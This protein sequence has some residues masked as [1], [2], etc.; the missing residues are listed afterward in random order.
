MKAG[1]KRPWAHVH[2]KLKSISSQKDPFPAAKAALRQGPNHTFQLPLLILKFPRER[3]ELFLL[4]MQEGVSASQAVLQKGVTTL[5]NRCPGLCRV[6]R[7]WTLCPSS[8]PVPAT[9]MFPGNREE[10]SLCARRGGH[11]RAHSLRPGS[12][13]DAGRLVDAPRGPEGLS[14]VPGGRRVG[15]MVTFQ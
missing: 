4:I 10:R 1:Q 15:D 13:V 2:R 3:V 11:R 9:G 6:T 8:E 7:G 14:L 5:L 12:L